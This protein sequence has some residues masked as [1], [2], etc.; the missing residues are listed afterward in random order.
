MARRDLIQHKL[1]TEYENEVIEVLE[2]CGD[3]ANTD[4]YAK[5]VLGVTP[6]ALKA[7]LMTN[8]AKEAAARATPESRKA[9]RRYA[10][11]YPSAPSHVLVDELR[12]VPGLSI[13]EEEIPG[14]LASAFRL[15]K[16]KTNND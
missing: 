12:D 1:P 9:F 6:M 7:F 4:F 14:E 2:Y 10:R 15:I 16:T 8:R 11:N 13:I 3:I 5:E